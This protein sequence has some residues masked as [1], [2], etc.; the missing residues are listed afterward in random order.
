MAALNEDMTADGEP[1]HRQRRNPVSP[2]LSPFKWAAKSVAS[3]VDLDPAICVELCKI[4]RAQM[5]VVALALAHLEVNP[6]PEQGCLLL[7]GSFKQV[8]TKTLGRDP[9]PGLRRAV[10]H[11]PGKVLAKD[12]YR[13]LVSLLDHR[14]T[15]KLLFHS[16]RIDDALIDLLFATPPPIRRNVLQLAQSRGAHWSQYARLSEG[17]RV[18]VARGAADTFD[19]L[20]RSLASAKRPEQFLGKILSLCDSLPLPEAMP[21][22]QIGLARRLDSVSEIRALATRWQNCLREFISSVNSGQCAIYVW[23]NET[24]PATCL[25]RRCGRLGW[26]LDDVKGPRNAEIDTLNLEI[27]YQSFAEAKVPQVSMIETVGMILG[28]DDV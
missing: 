25:V 15:A 13:R 9:P 27:I 26:F 18:L 28:F 17:L 22:V 7:R 6:P 23:D 20:V 3:L 14:P 21:G 4:G 8:I 5:H 11:M 19:E 1:L 16:E 10:G 2:L 12:S 24:T